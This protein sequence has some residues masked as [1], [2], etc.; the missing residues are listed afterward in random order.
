MSESRTTLAAEIAAELETSLLD[1]ARGLAGKLHRAQQF[2]RLL[3]LYGLVRPFQLPEHET[4][5]LDITGMDAAYS[6]LPAFGGLLYGI[7]IHAHRLKMVQR[8]ILDASEEVRVHVGDLDFYEYL[9]RLRWKLI[10]HMYELLDDIITAPNPPQLILVSLPLLVAREEAGNREQIE[11]VQEEWEAMLQAINGFWTKHLDRLFPFNPTGIWLASLQPSSA[12]PL[13][14]ALRNNPRTSPDEI[15][16]ELAAYIESAWVGLRQ[17]GMSRLLY[18]LLTPQT[19]TI[20]YSA[21]DLGLDA[22]WEPKALKHSGILG[23]SFRSRPG[24]SIWL[25]QVAGHRTQWTSAALDQLA[26]TITQATIT[27]GEEAVPLPLWYAEQ[28]AT[29]PP[30]MLTLFRDLAK[31]Q[32]DLDSLKTQSQEM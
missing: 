20:A 31:E 29:F 4:S 9:K 30:A 11:P 13:F 24:S 12:W 5:T 2:Q 17:A 1:A 16:S 27:E 14:V 19:R 23:F 21:E 3:R 15:S 22:R 6:T 32:I 8:T 7:S 10:Q 28:L 25:A 26:A 18:R